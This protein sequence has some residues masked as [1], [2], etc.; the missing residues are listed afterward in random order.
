MSIEITL[1]NVKIS[2]RSKVLNNASIK[3]GD[4]II[5]LTNATIDSN[6]E[7]LQDLNIDSFCSTIQEKLQSLDKSSEEYK[8][9]EKLLNA[10]RKNKPEFAKQLLQHITSFAEGVAVNIIS[11]MILGH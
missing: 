3:G 9:I 2:G 8:Q 6:A 1:D 10:D 7:I 11:S 5:R 4:A